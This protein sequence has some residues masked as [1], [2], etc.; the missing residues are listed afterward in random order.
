M[1]LQ[2]F[3]GIGEGIRVYSC[4][5]RKGTQLLVS[6]VL[7]NSDAVV[8]CLSILRWGVSTRGAAIARFGLLSIRRVLLFCS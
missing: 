2:E 6:I 5:Q 7:L 8:C 1:R 4:G 3:L